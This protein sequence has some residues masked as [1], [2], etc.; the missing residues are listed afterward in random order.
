MTHPRTSCGGRIGRREKKYNIQETG[1]GN[2]NDWKDISPRDHSTTRIMAIPANSYI[3]KTETRK[4]GATTFGCRYTDDEDDDDGG[5]GSKRKRRF[6]RA[7]SVASVT[8]STT[9]SPLPSC[10]IPARILLARGDTSSAPCSCCSQSR[11]Q[12]LW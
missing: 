4:A 1:S 5:A 3:S 9:P 6:P 10:P 2:N 7:H 8:L 12:A 11:S